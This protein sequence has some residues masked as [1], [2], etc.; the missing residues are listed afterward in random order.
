MRAI[1]SG[2]RVPSA[3]GVPGVEAGRTRGLY[4]ARVGGTASS[5]VR[6]GV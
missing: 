5:P 2:V 6:I 1:G 4:S 3:D